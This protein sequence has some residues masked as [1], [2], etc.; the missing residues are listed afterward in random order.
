MR[1]D[2]NIALITYLS[3]R[4]K[5]LELPVFEFNFLSC[6]TFS[7]R[8]C[9]REWHATL[10]MN[11]KAQLIKRLHIAASSPLKDS[12]KQSVSMIF[13][14]FSFKISLIRCLRNL[15]NY[16]P[17]SYWNSKRFPKKRSAAV[18]VALFIGRCE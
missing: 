9:V 1:N 8:L 3:V 15:S 11:R 16:S 17:P 2:N 18:L 5:R 4:L 6:S 14:C 12:S 13:I 10:S 7:M